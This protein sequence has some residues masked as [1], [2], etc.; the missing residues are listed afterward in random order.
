MVT[1]ARCGEEYSVLITSDKR[2]FASGLN[3]AG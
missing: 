3:N 2:V 1:F